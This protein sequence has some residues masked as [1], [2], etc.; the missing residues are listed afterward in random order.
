MEGTS[1]ESPVQR[2]LCYLHAVEA[3]TDLDIMGAPGVDA[4]LSGLEQFV[5]LRDRA[6]CQWC[7]RR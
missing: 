5:P 7:A 6:P 3:E 4:L 2:H 1:E